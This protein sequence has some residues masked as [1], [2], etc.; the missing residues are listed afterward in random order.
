VGGY[1]RHEAGGQA[2]RREQDPGF[3][4]AAD[5]ELETVDQ[6][7]VAGRLSAHRKAFLK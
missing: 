6:F 1:P 5:L 7:L 3:E 4:H 2:S